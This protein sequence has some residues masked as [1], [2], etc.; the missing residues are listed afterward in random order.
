MENKYQLAVELIS[1]FEKLRLTAYNTDGANTWTIGYGTIKYPDGQCVKEGDTCT[2]DKAEFYLNNFLV[3][4]IYPRVNRLQEFNPFS[5]RIFAGICSLAYNIGSA[6]SSPDLRTAIIAKDY[7]TLFQVF[8]KFIYSKG[9]VCDG[10]V[11][12]RTAEIKFMKGE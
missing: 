6:L 12:R 5:D 1:S 9:K 7:E 4:N 8:N 11:N 3:L 10:L 2:V